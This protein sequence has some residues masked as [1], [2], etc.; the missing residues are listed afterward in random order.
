VLHNLGYEITG[1]DLQENSV[2][3][4]LRN[5]RL[6]VSI[7][8][9]PENVD[10]SDVVVVSSAIP[11]G[12]S[13]LVA[14]RRRRIPI[15]PRAE[16]LAELMRFR[17]GIA[18]AGTHGKTTTTSLIA[19]LL[20]EGNLDPTY[21]IGG[22]LNSSGTHA[23]LG[24]GRYLVAEA[25]ESDASFLHLHPVMA[26]LTNIDTDHLQN[27]G[28]DLERLRQTF[29]TFMQ[30]LPFY[31]LAVVCID[32]PVARLTIADLSKPM[33]TYGTNHDADFRASSIA[34]KVTMT[35]FSVSRPGR[36][37]WMTVNLN[38][39]GRHNVLNALAAIALAHELGV[40]DEAICN[41]LERFQGI[42]RRFQVRGELHI[43]DATATLI[44]DYAHHPT[45]I[46]ATIDTIREG[47]PD[48]RL[49]VAF[50]PH[51]YSRTRDLFEDLVQVLSQVDA[52]LLLEVY[53]AC[54]KPIAGADGRALCRGIRLRGKIDPLF[55][56]DPADLSSALPS[57]LQDG[58]ILLTLGAGSVGGIVSQLVEQYG[59]GSS[60]AKQES[61]I[62]RI[63][64]A[65][66]TVHNKRR[67]Y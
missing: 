8:H 53:P 47:W 65:A 23:R 26:V 56:F 1:S 28:G 46:A 5:L 3:Q 33:L 61:R 2:T 14:A 12:N 48:R 55:L 25:D 11:P 7:G 36:A 29:T 58:D 38:L 57:L 49:V 42:A 51:R 63:R 50:Q 24:E 64:P 43:G 39:P 15:V 59:S 27:Y 30:R 60:G 10:H 41:G 4:H 19:S 20:A 35:R 9:G 13:E 31:G 21:V 32:D 62:V 16:M 67:G 45:E 44:D 34:Q 17:H 6:K 18:V 37:D 66:R 22:C 40:S 52:L 54:E